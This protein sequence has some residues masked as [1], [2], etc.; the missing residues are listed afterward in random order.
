MPCGCPSRTMPCK[1][2]PRLLAC[3]VV[4]QAVQQDVQVEG[5]KVVAHKHVGI[6]L[7]QPRHQHRQQRAL[8]GLWVQGQAQT[9]GWV[10]AARH[11]QLLRWGTSLCTCIN[12]TKVHL[13]GLDPPAWTA[14]RRR[15]AAQCPTGWPCAPRHQSLHGQCDHIGKAGRRCH[16]PPTAATSGATRM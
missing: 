12:L 11:M 3:L 7:A 2:A 15:S 5:G 1:Q 6:N 8:V 13:D 16:W 4:L 10:A 9:R 14:W